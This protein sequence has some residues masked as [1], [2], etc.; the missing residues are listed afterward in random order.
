MDLGT[1]KAE[2]LFL[3]LN[4]NEETV[5]SFDF[6]SDR[7]QL[8]LGFNS[9]LVA[10]AHFH[11]KPTTAAEIIFKTY[12]F[13]NPLPSF[14]QQQLSISALDVEVTATA[15]DSTGKMGLVSFRSGKTTLI[16]L[17]EHT[18]LFTLKAE[19]IHNRFLSDSRLLTFADDGSGSVW[20]FLHL[21]KPAKPVIQENFTY[22]NVLPGTDYFCAILDILDKKKRGK[23]PHL[24]IFKKEELLARS[25][26]VA[27]YQFLTAKKSK[28]SCLCV[29][30][31]KRHGSFSALDLSDLNSISMS[32]WSRKLNKASVKQQSQQA[33]VNG[34]ADFRINE[35]G[36]WLAAIAWPNRDV[37]VINLKV[38]NPQWLQLNIPIFNKLSIERRQLA[39][40]P[41]KPESL[42][43]LAILDSRGYTTL[44]SL[45]DWN[46]PI[47]VW[48][49][50]VNAFENSGRIEYTSSGDYLIN[51]SPETA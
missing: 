7:T 38:D 20:D 39:F 34:F 37:F 47:R 35:N 49:E 46:K 31:N 32:A 40:R 28:K 50:G 29:F 10:L 43:Q 45:E 23:W 19:G 15:I 33:L 21:A 6:S 17:K 16:N 13:S 42:T 48:S 44:A 41:E 12:Q 25:N 30:L 11:A 2:K 36:T 24:F 9:G 22:A 4:L 51:Y 5:T 3:D 14:R 1:Q 8:L 27:F 18:N 26:G